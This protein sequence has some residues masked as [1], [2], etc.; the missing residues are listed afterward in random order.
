MR[1]LELKIPPP[2]VALIVAVAM[3]S[4]SL[5][6]SRLELPATLPAFTPSMQ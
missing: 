3:W 1:T 2:V 6:T 4:V 5:A